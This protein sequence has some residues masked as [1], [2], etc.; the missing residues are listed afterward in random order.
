MLDKTACDVFEHGLKAVRIRYR[1]VVAGYVP[2][3]EH[4]HLLVGEPSRSS[5][6]IA[7]QVLKQQTSRKLK[8]PGT[9]Q[10]WQR[11]YYD[12]NLHNEEKRIEKLRYMHRNQVNHPNDE[13]LSPGTPVKRGL[14]EEPED[15]PWS[16]FRHY[17]LGQLGVIEIESSWT[18]FQRENQFPEHLRYIDSSV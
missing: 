2:M 4:V 16:S 10:F 3:P 6:S 14:V 5:L 1:F 11:R 18:A 8:Q 12:F 13:D 17:A 15:W 9:V 7:L